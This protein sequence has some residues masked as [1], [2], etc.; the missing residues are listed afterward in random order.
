M[1]KRISII[2]QN[3]RRSHHR[4]SEIIISHAKDTSNKGSQDTEQA[5]LKLCIGFFSK[6]ASPR[7]T[8]EY[9]I[10]ITRM[11]KSIQMIKNNPIK[12]NGIIIHPENNFTIESIQ[13][14]KFLS[15]KRFG[16]S[17]LTIWVKTVL[18]IRMMSQENKLA[19]VG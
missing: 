10:R 19:R 2:A 15:A 1:F 16:I 4:G 14:R 8:S 18:S 13:E 5:W 17:I 12:Y 6:V 3:R 9:S 7:V 11:I